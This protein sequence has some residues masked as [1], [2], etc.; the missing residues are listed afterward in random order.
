MVNQLFIFLNGQLWFLLTIKKHPFDLYK[1]S[2][3]AIT[4]D[5]VIRRIN[6]L[7]QP[8]RIA[9]RNN[10]CES[11]LVWFS[12]YLYL[13]IMI[14]QVKQCYASFPNNEVAIISSIVCRI[15]MPVN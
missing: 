6:S 8:Q 10:R 13:D 1:K 12:S 4:S 15:N 9:A 2:L 3:A 7:Y 11:F 14:P 5:F